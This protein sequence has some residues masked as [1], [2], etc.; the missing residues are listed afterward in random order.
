MKAEGLFKLGPIGGK[1]KSGFDL[2][3]SG[4]KIGGVEKEV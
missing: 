1:G 4:G 2:H 3:V